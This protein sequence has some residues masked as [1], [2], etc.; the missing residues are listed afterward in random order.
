MQGYGVLS[1]AFSLVRP[2]CS[3]SPFPSPHLKGAGIGNSGT[4]PRPRFEGCARQPSGQEARSA[5][6]FRKDCQ[7]CNEA[8]KPSC[9]APQINLPR[10]LSPPSHGSADRRLRPVAGVW[11]CW[12]ACSWTSRRHAITLC[13]H[14][15]WPKTS[16]CCTTTLGTLFVT[17]TTR[18]RG[19]LIFS[20]LEISTWRITHTVKILV[21]SVPVHSSW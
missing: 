17:V 7:G 18:P 8:R 10:R 13:Q 4:S 9:T 1:C 12:R 15:R 11:C 3:G 16:D 19:L 14:R 21:S 20:P 6:L 2:H 5:N